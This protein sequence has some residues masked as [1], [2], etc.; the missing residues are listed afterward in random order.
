VSSAERRN[1]GISQSVRSLA[2]DTETSVEASP[3]GM[4]ASGSVM[5]A[6]PMKPMKAA[7]RS[8]AA[9]AG[10]TPIGMPP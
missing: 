1:Y 3:V 4:V 8:S 10:A 2:T 6:L 9:F 5:R 7:R